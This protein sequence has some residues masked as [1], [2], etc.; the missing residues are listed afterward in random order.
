MQ[1]LHTE[2]EDRGGNEVE[3]VFGGKRTNLHSVWDSLMPAK[4][5]GGSTHDTEMRDAMR[6]AVKLFAEDERGLQGECTHDAEMCALGW[7]EDS[8]RFVCEYVLAEDITG[9]LAGEYFEGAVEIVQGQLRKGGRALAAWINM[10]A[11]EYYH[12]EL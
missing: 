7:A 5:V 6:W 8:N 12:G 4:V 9:D 10:L 2:A 11:N 3:V 1:P